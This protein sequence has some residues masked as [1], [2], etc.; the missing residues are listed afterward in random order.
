MKL[1]EVLKP[2][3]S[4]KTSFLT[5]AL[6]GPTE[7]LPCCSST[8][9][10]AAKGAPIHIAYSIDAHSIW[11]LGV[12]VSS[13]LWTVI[14]PLTELRPRSTKKT[15]QTFCYRTYVRSYVRNGGRGQL[16]SE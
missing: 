9:L 13:N 14:V 5:G 1:S 10:A 15:N 7:S 11:D 2:L 6:P 8:L 4:I 16:T 3:E 12:S